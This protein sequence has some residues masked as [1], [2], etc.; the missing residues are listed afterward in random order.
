MVAL[1]RLGAKIGANAAIDRN[2][3]RRNQFIAVPPRAET[4]GSEKAVQAHKGA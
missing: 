1:D 3:T 2:P 4:S